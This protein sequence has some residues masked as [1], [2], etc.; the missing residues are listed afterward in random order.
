MSARLAGIAVVLAACTGTPS[1]LGLQEPIRV[2]NGT[3][4]AG[5]LPGDPFDAAA[6][7]TDPA[8]TLIETANNVV[9]VGQAGKRISGRA[10]IDAIAVGIAF[11]GLGS[12]YWVAP[13]GPPDPAAGNEYTWTLDASIGW[14]LP[15]G[16]QAIELVAIGEHGVAGR[17]AR[18]SV[19]VR[20]DLL[21]NFTSC[22]P[23][24][25][26]PDTVLALSWDADVD[27]DLLV[28][29]PSGKLVDPSH[30]ST[31]AH[32]PV[33]A[34]DLAADHVGILD[35]DSNVNCTIDGINRE[36]LVWQT[37]PEP[38][39]YEVYA[40]LADACGQGAVRFTATLYRA[41]PAGDGTSQLVEISHQDGRLLGAAADG[42]RGPGLFLFQLAL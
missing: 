29:T 40:E 18:T 31:V 8:I 15:L 3:F 30:P 12:G 2:R 7:I 38:G 32:Q 37:A 35:R 10:S 19:C 26:P 6:P 27:L 33:T 20:P 23:S 36:A 28:R 9:R 22:D 13:V 1:V 24:L 39:T 21:D 5:E 41:Q 11:A 16:P 25:A 17:Q 4:V 34:A 42:G 14:D